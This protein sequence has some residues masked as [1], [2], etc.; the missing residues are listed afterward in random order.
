MGHVTRIREKRNA[1]RVLM[2]KKLKENIERRRHRWKGD[3]QV[4]LK[5]ILWEGVDWI[6]MPQDKQKWMS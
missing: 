5:E 1:H 3:I 6:N 4:H 2:G